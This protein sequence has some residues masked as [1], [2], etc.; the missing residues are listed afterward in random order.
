[1]KTINHPL[2]VEAEHWNKLLEF[3]K[4][5]AKVKDDLYYQI[6]EEKIINEQGYKC[7]RVICISKVSREL[8]KEIGEET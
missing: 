1:M 7:G 8:L 2:I 6:P 5:L 3:V 4:D